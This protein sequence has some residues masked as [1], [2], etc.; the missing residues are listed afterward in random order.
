[1]LYLLFFYA[2]K[3]TTFS[4]FR[5]GVYMYMYICT[6][7]SLEVSLFNVIW[8][9]SVHI[10]RYIL[11]E[12]VV[13]LIMKLMFSSFGAYFVCGGYRDID[14]ESFCLLQMLRSEISTPRW[15]CSEFMQQSL[16]GVNWYYQS[17]RTEKK[18]FGHICEWWYWQRAILFIAN[19]KKYQRPVDCA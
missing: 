3:S 13:I 14:K 2:C 19:A 12:V 17:K 11:C 1:M 18:L 5:T 10:I 9:C 4:K 16:R 8:S 7:V 15:L 6:T